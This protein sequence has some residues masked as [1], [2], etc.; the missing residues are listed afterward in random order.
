MDFDRIRYIITP[1][2]LENKTVIVVG[3]GSGGA[4][5]VQHLAMSG[6][7]NWVLFDPDVLDEVNL[8]RHP[9][10]R[11]DI[12]RNKVT[13]MAKWLQD[14]NPGCEIQEFPENILDSTDFERQVKRADLVLSATDTLS[15]RQFINRICVRHATPCITASVFRTAVGGEVYSYI[16]HETGCYQ[17]LNT[18]SNKLGW[19]QI[20]NAVEMTDDEQH[21]IYG[22]GEEEYRASGLSMD[23]GIISAIMA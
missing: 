1:E 10:M 15:V 2:E 7:R 16:P 4:P 17:C 20:E 18:V 23:I 19:S 21:R 6:V 13:I 9:G 22:L 3:V 11:R 14:R 8:V 12:G 5:V